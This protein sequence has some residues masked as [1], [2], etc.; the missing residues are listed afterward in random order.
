MAD[1]TMTT[2]SNQFHAPRKKARPIA[3]ILMIISTT[4]IATTVT[5][6]PISSGSS[7]ALTLAAVRQPS[8]IALITSTMTITRLNHGAAT[9][10]WH[11]ARIRTPGA[12][13]Q[14]RPGAPGP[15]PG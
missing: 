3:V 5:S 6:M 14:P 8:A 9:R 11:R 12:A 1:S 2:R 4:K 15:R 7:E 13:R 10:R